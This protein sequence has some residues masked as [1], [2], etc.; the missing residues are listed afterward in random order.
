[1]FK[2]KIHPRISETN[3]TGHISHSAIPVW[4]EEGYEEIL[5]LFPQHHNNPSLVMVNINIDF[6]RELFFGKDV[7]LITGVEKI[8]NTSLTLKQLLFQDEAL[9]VVSNTTFVH[10]DQVSRKPSPIPEPIRKILSEHLYKE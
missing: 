7:E 10:L 2:R 5:M 6:L 4:L 8:G 9:C 3:L 1:M